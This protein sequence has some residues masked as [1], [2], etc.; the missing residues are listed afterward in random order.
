MT[1]WHLV[2][3]NRGNMFILTDQNIHSGKGCNAGSLSR[4][5]SR[6]SKYKQYRPAQTHPTNQST[7]PHIDLS[8]YVGHDHSKT[9]QRLTK[10]CHFWH[11][12]AQYWQNHLP[13]DIQNFKEILNSDQPNLITLPS[14]LCLSIFL[15]L[16]TPRRVVSTPRSQVTLTDTSISFLVVQMK[17]LYQIK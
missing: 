8:G 14:V 6:P 5:V 15:P 16:S 9:K 12:V 11:K 2:V 1:K 10:C 3:S 13:L 4:G 7:S 17:V